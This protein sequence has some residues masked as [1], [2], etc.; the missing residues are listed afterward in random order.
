M[1]KQNVNKKNNCAPALKLILILIL[2]SIVASC[3]KKS[4]E[5]ITIMSGNFRQ[6]VIETGELQAVNASFI[7]MPEI[8]YI[9]G[10]N[11]KII[12]LAEHGK[13][14]QK[15]DSVV[16]IDASSI[17]KYIIE[18]QEALENELASSN[19]QKVQLENAMQD[20]RAQFKNEQAAFD[21]KKLEVDRSSFESENKRKVKQ[22]E[23][24]QAEIRLN[25]I[26]RSLN[27]KPRLD[28]LDRRIQQ[29]QVSQKEL[30]LAIAKETLTI[31]LIR[32]PLDGIFEVESNYRTGQ[33]LKVGDEMYTGS[34]IASI[35]D[36][37]KMKVKTSVHE[38]EIK[39][40]KDGMKVIV[41]LDALPSVAFHGV[42]TAIAKTCSDNRQ[43][44]EENVDKEK[45]FNIEVVIEESDLR[46]KPGMTV[47]CEYIC[48]ESDKD[49]FVPN[50][51][52]LSEKKHSY[53]F[54]KRRGSVKKVEVVKG[55]SN[56]YYTVIK[57]VVKSGQSLELPE[58]VIPN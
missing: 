7:F 49:L 44:W 3:K 4:A 48:Y 32:S 36:L 26:N 41:R 56:T 28:S 42:V 12:G 22:L 17:Y 51:S 5:E 43:Y 23:F 13:S 19:K 27:L 6:S 24:R 21:L 2:I 30:E 14:V 10:Y 39:K 15:G 47:S 8:N 1:K 16:K 29:I 53:I 35:P 37:R 31:M 46:L 55:P 33:T 20:L 9:Y 11:F 38:T 34:M 45:V 54:I 57:G 25:K 50:R 40:I 18:K 52:L 58:N